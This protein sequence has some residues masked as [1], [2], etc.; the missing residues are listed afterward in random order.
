MP[1]CFYARLVDEE[2]KTSFSK[3]PR[4]P[5]IKNYVIEGLI[6]YNRAKEHFRFMRMMGRD[7]AYIYDGL[8]KRYI[9][10]R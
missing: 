10:S 8:Q 4:I 5:Q 1:D 7:Y 2:K 6:Q 3:K 9:D